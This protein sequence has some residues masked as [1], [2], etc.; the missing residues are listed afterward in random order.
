VNGTSRP[1]RKPEEPRNSGL[2]G[3]LLASSFLAD[4]I[5]QSVVCPLRPPLRP[6]WLA[7]SRPAR[8]RS[9]VSSQEDRQRQVQAFAVAL[10]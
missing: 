6:S 9:M 7:T 8:V 3:T 10:T 5:L 4:L 1:S 2:G